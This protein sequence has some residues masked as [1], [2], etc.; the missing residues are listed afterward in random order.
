LEK[1]LS[2]IATSSAPGIYAYARAAKDAGLDIITW[3]LERSGPLKGTTDF[4][5]LSVASAIERDGD[6]MVVLDVLA[7]DVGVRGV[8][9]D[10]PATV[11]YYANCMGL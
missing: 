3:T 7:Q 10:W 4:Y 6:M 8:F 5:Y 9:S 11:T 1:L 2:S